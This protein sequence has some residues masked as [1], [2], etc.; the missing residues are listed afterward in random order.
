MQTSRLKNL[1]SVSLCLLVSAGCA[2]S[3]FDGY[4]PAVRHEIETDQHVFWFRDESA[5]SLFT[6]SFDFRNDHFSGLMVFHPI[7]DSGY[8]MILLTQFGLKVFDLEYA[9]ETGFVIHYIMPSLDRKSVI[10]LLQNDLGLLPAYPVRMQEARP[11]FD[12]KTG[13][14][15]MQ[16]RGNRKVYD[17]F[18]SDETGKIYRIVQSSRLFRQVQVDYYS[19]GGTRLDSVAIKHYRSKLNIKL[20][21]INEITTPADGQAVS[22]RGFAAR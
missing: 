10:R 3:L 17:C 13:S 19:T 18:I 12:G 5:Q 2:I 7:P 1:I 15:V 6:A 22:D 4:H 14:L 11:F 8:R 20:I 9:Q 16:E 21:R